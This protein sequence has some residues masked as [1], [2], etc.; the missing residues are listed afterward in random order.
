MLFNMNFHLYNAVLCHIHKMVS[1]NKICYCIYMLT[2][3]YDYKLFQ[4][5]IITE[6][7]G[8]LIQLNRLLRY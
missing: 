6:P 3:G 7:V 4:V 8:Q 1:V 5:V 2:N